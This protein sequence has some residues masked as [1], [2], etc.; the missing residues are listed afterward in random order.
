MS[1]KVL[2]SFGWRCVI[3]SLL[4]FWGALFGYLAYINTDVEQENEI[5]SILLAEEEEGIPSKS[6][7]K[8]KTIIHVQQPSNDIDNKP[9][10]TGIQVPNMLNMVPPEYTNTSE[11]ATICPLRKNV[12]IKDKHW[13]TVDNSSIFNGIP[14][15]KY[16]KGIICNS[17]KALYEPLAL[18]KCPIYNNISII[19]LGQYYPHMFHHVWG[20]V[21]NG[22]WE[23]S[24]MSSIISR[25]HHLVY[26]QLDYQQLYMFHE[27][28]LE[29]FTFH[30]IQHYKNLLL[31]PMEAIKHMIMD[32][33]NYEVED[34]THAPH[35]CACVKEVYFC[36]FSTDFK[37]NYPQGFLTRLHPKDGDYF[38]WDRVEWYKQYWH[39]K[40]V[41][42]DNTRFIEEFFGSQRLKDDKPIIGLIDKRKNGKWL[43]IEEVQKQC[44]SMEMNYHC[45][46]LRMYEI[47]QPIELLWIMNKIDI[48]VGFHSNS[49]VQGGLWLPHTSSIVEILP[50]N[51]LASWLDLPGG[52]TPLKWTFQKVPQR[53][54]WFQLYHDENPHKKAYDAGKTDFNLEF[55]ELDKIMQFLLQHPNDFCYGYD[56]VMTLPIYL[57]DRNFTFDSKNFDEDGVMYQYKPDCNR[58]IEWTNNR[59]NDL[60]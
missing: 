22:L 30:P 19:M 34:K 54:A 31:D 45:K 6:I 8:H 27:L 14:S 39:K 59:I 32:D 60:V 28:L 17:F 37:Q 3:L 10:L 53:H 38:T 7:N 15:I 18:N 47:Q 51:P 41:K 5:E 24:I 2:V 52:G 56:E 11:F 13:L 9:I 43:N 55:K 49:I 1:S 20:R 26:E 57:K 36:G 50:A 21:V 42:D 29:P 4:C 33:N 12:C 40:H 25:N 23:Y 44:D 48:L 58:K 46:I 35:N 16:C